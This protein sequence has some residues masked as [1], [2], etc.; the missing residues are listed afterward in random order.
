M[1]QLKSSGGLAHGRGLNASMQ[2][3]FVNVIPRCVPVCNELETFCG[4]HAQTSEQHSDLRPTTSDRDATHFSTI[5]NWMKEHSP[6]A[7]AAI[8]GLVNIATGIVAESSSNADNAYDIGKSAADKL[9]GQKYGETKLKKTDKVTSISAASNAINVRGKEVDVNSSLLFGHITCIL[10]KK[11][12]MADH[13]WIFKET[14]Y[15]VRQWFNEKNSQKCCC[16]DHQR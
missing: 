1:R 5:Y 4:V 6:F 8:D 14:T 7:Y 3:K 10:K 13:L 12:E 11:Q 9:T 2:S 15:T 16:Q